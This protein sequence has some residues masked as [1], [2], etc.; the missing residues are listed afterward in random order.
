MISKKDIA[1]IA[2][3]ILKRQR[4]LRDHQIIH[5]AREW[6]V[7][8]GLSLL[9]LIGGAT[10]SAFTYIEVSKRT[11]ET[12]ETEVVTANVYRADIV[13]AALSKFRERTDNFNQLLQNR[14]QVIPAQ[15]TEVT[16]PV[17]ADVPPEIAPE[18]IVPS[19]DG[20]ESGTD[21]APTEASGEEVSSE[22]ATIPETTTNTT[23]IDFN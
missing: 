8:L 5:P 23:S 21:T 7:G 9:I 2:K 1:K 14:T 16:L 22:S 17:P 12:T 6:F 19:D 4:G 3:Q 15:S 20:V 10:W 13:N 11:V 18:E